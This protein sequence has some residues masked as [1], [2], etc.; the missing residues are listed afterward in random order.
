MIKP[1][2]LSS[3]KIV[4][5][6]RKLL[7]WGKNNFAKFSWRNH[8]K[9][10]HSLIVEIL[11]QR[12]RAE[13]V[14]PVYKQFKKKFPSPLSLSKANIE[15]VEKIIY[16]LGLKWRAG[17]VLKLGNE[18]Y[19]KYK[20]IPP[21]QIE[22]LLKL[23]GVGPYAAGACLSLHSGIRAIIP[24]ANMVRIL[25][26]VFGFPYH[27]ETRKDKDFL[28]LCDLVTPKR[29]FKEFNYAILDFGRDICTPKNPKHLICPLKN[30]CHYY[31]RI[32]REGNEL[33]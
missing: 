33:N 15:D 32:R 29:K 5:F 31:K 10:F 13:Q 14:V 17:N 16:P 26:R 24:D 1:K 18:I 30:V 3:R 4:F 11:L 9:P 27:A 25:G 20:G 21:L 8:G 2:E 28:I 12:T 22:E 23:P 19:F 7:I 6:Q